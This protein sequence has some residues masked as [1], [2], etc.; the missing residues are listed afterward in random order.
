VSLGQNC[1]SLNKCRVNN[2]AVLVCH[3]LLLC[4]IRTKT[5][6]NTP[7]AIVKRKSCIFEMLA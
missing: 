4:W 2:I 5:R 6:L 3:H 7:S 1:S